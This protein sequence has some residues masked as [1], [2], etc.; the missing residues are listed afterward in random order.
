[1]L[2]PPSQSFKF[3]NP[4]RTAAAIRSALSSSSSTTTTTTSGAPERKF[5]SADALFGEPPP[6]YIPGAGRGATGFTTRSDIGPARIPSSRFDSRASQSDDATSGGSTTSG[7]GIHDF[8]NA[9]STF[10]ESNT[11]EDDQDAMI[12]SSSFDEWSGYGDNTLGRVTGLEDEEDREADAVWDHVAQRLESKRKKKKLNHDDNMTTNHDTMTPITPITPMTPT[13]ETPSSQTSS[14]YSKYS[15]LTQSLDSQ[16]PMIASTFSDIKE[17]LKYLSKQEWANIPEV[18]GSTASTLK[19]PNRM[20]QQMYERYTPTPDHLLMDQFNAQMSGGTRV[21]MDPSI[22]SSSSISSSISSSSI[23]SSTTTTTIPKNLQGQSGT[24]TDLRALGEMRESIMNSKLQSLEDSVG[25]KS[26]IDPKNYMS[27]LESQIVLG[28]DQYADIKRYRKLF[29]KAIQVK[30][31]NASSWIGR[32]RLEELAG[33]LKKACHVIAKGCHV[34]KNSEELWLESIRLHLQYYGSG[35]ASTISIDIIGSHN[36]NTSRNSNTSHNTNQSHGTTSPTLVQSICCEAIEH[37]PHSVKLWLKACELESDLEKKKKILR[38]AISTQPQSIQLWKEAIE[39]EQDESNAKT[40]LERAIECI[41]TSVELW[42]A[43]AKLNDYTNAKKILSRAVSKLPKEPQIWIAG[44]YLEEEHSNHESS[45]RNLI[46]KAI[47][48]LK[49]LTMMNKTVNHME[50]NTMNDMKNN[51]TTLTTTTNNISNH[52]SSS[53]SREEWMEYAKQAEKTQHLLTCRAIIQEIISFGLNDTKDVEH[54][55]EKKH[56]YLNDAHTCA[57]QGYIETARAIYDCARLEFPN[58]KS[59]WLNIYEFESKC[60]DNARMEH[61]TLCMTSTT[62]SMTSTTPMTSSEDSNSSQTSRLRQ[63]LSQA[64][65]NCPNCEDLWLIRAKYEW[66]VFNNIENARQVLEE[67][68]KNEIN[69]NNENIWLA[70]VKLEFENEEYLRARLLLEHA[71]SHF[72]RDYVN[73]ISS[74]S[75]SHD[76][77]TSVV[78]VGSSSSSSSHS[79]SSNISHSSSSHSHHHHNDHGIHVWIRSIQFERR[80]FHH[81]SMKQILLSQIEMYQKEQQQQD[82]SPLALQITSMEESILT[83]ALEKYPK[84]DKLWLMRGQYEEEQLYRCSLEVSCSIHTT[85]NSMN[86]TNNSMN[87]QDDISLLHLKTCKI[88][89]DGLKHCPNS[90]P[91]WL[92]LFRLYFNPLV[93]SP[94]MMNITKARALLDR[95]LLKNPSSASLWLALVKLEYYHTCSIGNSIGNSSIGSGSITGNNSGSSDKIHTPPPPPPPLTLLSTCLATLSKGIQSM[96]LSVSSHKKTKNPSSSS[97]GSSGILWS[98]T[99]PLEIVQKRKAAIANALKH[100]DRDPYVILQIALDFYRERRFEKAKE[101]LRKA[102][103]V[104]PTNGDLWI[105][106]YRMEL[107]LHNVSLTTSSS[108]SSSSQQQQS[109]LAIEEEYMSMKN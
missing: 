26:T 101:W 104:D 61:S 27:G 18:S 72:D 53:L 32:A 3:N 40:L 49:K 78:V 99:I 21:R 106:L 15:M 109:L 89:E 95:A 93:K 58:K 70:F 100:C 74:S 19:N 24:L 102:L 71:R 13:F 17:Q 57:S 65:L 41:P 69:Q 77:G 66:K 108:S 94:Y 9:S 90:I 67:A 38:K 87:T 33:D 73:S 14:K 42:L 23:S 10:N 28:T 16:K 29:K 55:K 44:A 81:E 64:T 83:Q 46:K 91:L 47:D 22:S 8:I 20:N 86:T 68:F 37:L 39:L 85:N 96:N 62:P 2:P 5:V 76:A 52:H 34:V 45:V 36:S 97:S 98:F 7:G 6:G 88:Y 43:L 50:S 60:Q 63:L 4:K 48:T 79:S 59:V 84:Q 80:V 107:E 92:S 82:S 105:F 1:M 54:L 12:N 51:M 56:V 31:M 25:G 75:S 11:M 103:T 35:G 30:P